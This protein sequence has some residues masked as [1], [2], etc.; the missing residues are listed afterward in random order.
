MRIMHRRGAKLVLAMAVA[1]GVFGIVTVVQAAI[2]DAA[3]VAHGCVVAN[4]PIPAKNYL[5]MVD[6]EHGMFC[7]PYETPVNFAASSGTAFAGAEVWYGN[8]EVFNT[9]G[10]GTVA[11]VNVPVGVFLV[12]ATGWAAG[13]TAGVKNIRCFINTPQGDAADTF[14]SVGLDVTDIG[15][16][17][18]WAT[19]QLVSKA[20]AGP[21]NAR[22]LDSSTDG[23]I[24]EGAQITAVKMLTTHGTVFAGAPSSGGPTSATPTHH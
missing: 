2:P 8:G 5:R 20:A 21:I 9:S 15:G 10:G 4:N 1:A 14:T 17:T 6:T 24:L 18:S 12:H 3:G 23:T 11:S 13:L 19:Q 22:C 7:Q 16:Q